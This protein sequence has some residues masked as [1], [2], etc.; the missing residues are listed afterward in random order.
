MSEEK[1]SPV[2]GWRPIER[3]PSS[4]KG[5]L[6]T[7]N[8]DLIKEFK[9]KNI[10]VSNETLKK[11]RIKSESDLTLVFYHPFD[12]DNVILSTIMLSKNKKEVGSIFIHNKGNQ[13]L[14]DYKEFKEGNKQGQIINL[15]AIPDDD[16]SI[17]NIKSAFEEFEKSQHSKD[18]KCREECGNT[19][20]STI[21]ENT[22]FVEKPVSG[23]SNSQD[24]VSE[25]QQ[26]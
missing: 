7:F 8:P 10:K 11:L 17:T 13:Y 21:A 25:Q 12:Y 23:N 2:E 19:L 4:S 16:K 1:M 20:L 18:E 9:Q 22:D 14:L 6:R 26:Y 24:S 5:G 3:L 15:G